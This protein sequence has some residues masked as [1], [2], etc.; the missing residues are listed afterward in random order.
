MGGLPAWPGFAQ[1]GLCARTSGVSELRTSTSA[2]P[3]TVQISIRMICSLAHLIFN[4]ASFD[5]GLEDVVEEPLYFEVNLSAICKF[6]SR[7][8]G[9]GRNRGLYPDRRT[10]HVSRRQPKLETLRS[11]G[12]PPR[13]PATGL[14]LAS[15]RVR[16]ASLPLASPGEESDSVA[17]YDEAKLLRLNRHARTCPVTKTTIASPAAPASER[18]PPPPSKR[19]P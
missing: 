8:P 10:R 1:T 19:F 11:L 16:G 5:D 18:P 14:H 12:S 6:I 3:G 17:C 2:P 15:L 9:K 7:R 4:G 13:A